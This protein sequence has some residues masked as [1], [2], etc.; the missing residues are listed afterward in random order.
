MTAKEKMNKK[1]KE[2]KTEDLLQEMDLLY[3]NANGRNPDREK[4]L[5]EKNVGYDLFLGFL[6]E[7]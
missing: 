6:L 3:L 2:T 7:D 5:S 1:P 4:E